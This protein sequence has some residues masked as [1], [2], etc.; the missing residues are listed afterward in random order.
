MD[1]KIDFFFFLKKKIVYKQ[2]NWKVKNGFKKAKWNNIM[3]KDIEIE[4]KAILTNA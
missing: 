3:I 2:Q 1:V 4:I